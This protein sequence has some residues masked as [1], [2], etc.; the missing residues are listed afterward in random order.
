[1]KSP[2]FHLD[3]FK[4]EIRP[5]SFVV[6]NWWNGDLQVCVVTKLS[7]KMVQLKRVKSSTRTHTLKSKY[8]DQMLVVDNEDVTLYVLG[9]CN[10]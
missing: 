6:T 5:G 7:P 2:A 8:P 9:N 1:M 10:E 4:K 3:I